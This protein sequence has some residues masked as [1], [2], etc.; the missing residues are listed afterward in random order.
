MQT[1]F[2]PFLAVYLTAAGWT[3]TSIGVAL[4]IG[5]VT[6]MASQVPAGALV[7]AVRRKTRVAVFS[8]LAFTA[9]ALLFTIEPIPLF[10]YLGQILH[11]FSS[12]TLGPSI[13][14]MSFA[15]AGQMALGTRLGRNARF[16]AIGSGL[17]AALMGACGYYISERAVFFL[18]AIF[19]FPALAALIPLAG[20]ADRTPPALRRQRRRRRTDRNRI[21]LGEM[22]STLADKRLLIFAACVTL[23]TFANAPLLPLASGAITKRA[24]E[25]ATLLIAACI[26]IPQVI[27]AFISPT[28]GRFAETR[29]R[30][31]VL[32]VGFSILPIRGVLLGLITDPALVVMVQALDG[33]AAACFGVMMPLVTTDIAARSG[34]MNLSL[35]FMGFSV[36]VGATLSTTIAGWIADTYGEATAFYSLASVGVVAVL[37]VVLAMRETRPEPEPQPAS[38]DES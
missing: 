24:S 20:V 29:G 33:I 19:T 3:Q 35:G 13:V 16:S 30:K 10:V 1:G 23:F 11:A 12:C 25:E 2:G 4:S 34:H 15:V 17:G 6:A 27:V 22:L 7:D 18:T 38:E 9:S 8:I 32:I 26:I 36:G 37:L 21:R 31:I 28:V 5:T 14:A